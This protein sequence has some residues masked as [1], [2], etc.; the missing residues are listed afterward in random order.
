MLVEL[1]SLFVWV[2]SGLRSACLSLFEAVAFISKAG[3][4]RGEASPYGNVLM[5]W[6]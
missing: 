5:L 2:K 3:A 6:I 4:E 1:L